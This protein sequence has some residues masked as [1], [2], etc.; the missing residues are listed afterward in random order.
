MLCTHTHV[1]AASHEFEGTE[2]EHEQLPGRSWA[3]AG[4]I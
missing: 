3:R 1:E 2:A 4:L